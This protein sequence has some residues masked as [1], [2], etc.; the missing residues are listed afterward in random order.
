MPQIN[1]IQNV[2]KDLDL[3]FEA[4]PVTGDI[5]KLSNEEAVKRSIRNLVLLNHYEIFTHPEIA[6]GVTQLL[7][8]N[9]ETNTARVIQRLITELIKNFEPRAELQD[10]VS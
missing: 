3:D 10:V 7:F 6:S 2:F 9:M 5:S 1:V 8:E 4:H